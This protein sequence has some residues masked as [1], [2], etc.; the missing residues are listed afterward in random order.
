MASNFSQMLA[1][2]SHLHSVFPP[3]FTNACVPHGAVH[4]VSWLTA[5]AAE[6]VPSL[7]PG[8]SPLG[9]RSLPR[10]PGGCSPLPAV[11]R[12]KHVIS[13]YHAE[14]D[15]CHPSHA[16][17]R[18]PWSILQILREDAVIP[19]NWAF[20]REKWGK[21]YSC[22]PRLCFELFNWWENSLTGPAAAPQPLLKIRFKPLAL[23]YPPLASLLSCFNNVH[24]AGTNPSQRPVVLETVHTE[25]RPVP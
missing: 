22:I 16:S 2:K 1:L 3:K 6:L 4:K 18:A 15:T 20:I 9:S 14:Q 5:P 21:P 8:H 10:C 11:L 7:L 12:E 19:K 23:K 24:C 25:L 13:E 17:V